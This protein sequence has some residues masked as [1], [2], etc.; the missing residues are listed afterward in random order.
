[1]RRLGY[2]GGYG[3]ACTLAPRLRLSHS[4]AQRMPMVF[5]GIDSGKTGEFGQ[6]SM[7]KNLIV[8]LGIGIA[9]AAWPPVFAQ[10]PSISPPG[11]HLLELE[12]RKA[13]T[14]PTI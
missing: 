4:N 13:D 12:N 11:D 9:F 1:M 3:F 6:S 10:T 14:A 5:D 8:V 7:P 2:V